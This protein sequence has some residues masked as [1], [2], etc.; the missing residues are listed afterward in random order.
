MKIR[1]KRAGEPTQ[2]VMTGNPEEKTFIEREGVH[3]ARRQLVYN[4]IPLSSY[5]SQIASDTDGP[6]WSL[7]EN[8]ATQ[9]LLSNFR[10]C[11]EMMKLSYIR[12]LT[13]IRLSGSLAFGTL[14]HEALDRVYSLFRE[15]QLVNKESLPGMAVT[16]YLN[17]QL[18]QIE[19]SD[20]QKVIQALQGDVE[21]FYEL[22]NNHGIAKV[23]LNSYFKQ[24]ASDYYSHKWESLEQRFEVS[25]TSPVTQNVIPI[26]GK[27]DGTYRADNG[28]LWLF[29]TKTSSRIEEN[30][31]SE[32]L[33]YELQVGMYV[34]AMKQI[35]GEV[36]AGV[37]YNI[38]RNP[39]LKQTK[40]ESLKQ[41]HA[42]IEA[43]VKQRPAHYFIRYEVS[44]LPDEMER[45]EEEFFRLLLQL[46]SWYNGGFHYRN[47]GSCQTK[48][49][50]CRYFPICSREDYTKFRAKDT[51]F[52]E[53]DKG[54]E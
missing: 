54:A 3:V 15:R 27:F 52:P 33:H 40:A 1:V 11:P 14:I 25:V 2:T 4:L 23:V 50:S 31:I 5:D 46:E 17:R 41:F 20:R 44:I 38:I 35:Y 32:C 7:Y 42:R 19:A 49:G 45:F 24:W 53:L 6:K 16:T 29:E 36:P 13:P 12:G 47:S 10:N 8:G 9:S 28:K 37:C 48:Y 22:E 34:W 21:A 51:V 43:D 18:E 30:N 39:S 26:R